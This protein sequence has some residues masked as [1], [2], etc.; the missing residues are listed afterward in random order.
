MKRALLILL[1]ACGDN[2]SD[3]EPGEELAGGE[4][5]VFE[6]GANAFSL[7]ARNLIGE[8]REKFFVGNS[9]FKRAWVT[10]PSSTSGVDGLGPTYN[11]TSCAACHF[12]DGRGA[13]PQEPDE[14]F[15]GLLVRLSV[16]GEAPDGGPLGD[17]VYGGQFNHKSLLDVPA[18]GTAKVTYVEVAGAFGDGSPFSLRQPSYQFDLAFGPFGE[19]IMISP[20]TGPAMVGLGLLEAIDESVIV[21]LADEGDADGDGISG[22]VNRVFDVRSRSAK[23]GRFGW[24]ANQP[25]LEQQVAGAFNG[26]IGITSTLFPDQNCPPAQTACAASP[27]GGTPE[28]ADDKIDEVTYYSQLLAVP[29]RRD[30]RDP[31]VLRGKALFHEAGC[32]SCHT[33]KL[34]TGE[35][36]GIPEVS[37]QTIFPYTDLL[38]HDLGDELADGRPD[39]LATGNEWRT[40]PLWGIGLVKVVNRHT[41][42]L[43]DGR[44]RDLS[45][46]I[47]WHGGEGEAAREAYRLMPESDR[48]A[49]IRFLES[50]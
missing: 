9:F 40:P 25:T 33:P 29:A 18:E 10:A 22:R 11:A 43:H 12:K 27:D 42:F 37:G 16:P 4:T 41:D 39:F 19:G 3:Y 20:R 45:E 8:R 35:L 2:A 36:A 13:P 31:V 17:P 38:L 23:L 15:L 32:A 30:F 49:L 26:D 28:I 48:G 5:T 34:V 14:E 6:E 24:K 1:V 46:A 21:E 47:L 44:A 50:L 7:A